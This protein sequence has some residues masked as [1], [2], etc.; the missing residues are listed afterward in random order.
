MGEDQD[1]RGREDS[2]GRRLHETISP[3]ER[4]LLVAAEAKNG[5][6]RDSWD[7]ASSLEELALLASTA[8]AQVVGRV[9]QRLE[10]PDPAYYVGRGKLQEIVSLRTTL[11]YDLVI[12]DDE[13]SPVQQRNLERA[14]QVKVL[15]RTA[16]ILDIFAQHARTREGRLQVELA[17]HE[18]LLPRL[19]GQWSHLERLGGGIGTRGPGETQLETDRRLIKRRIQHLRRELEEVRQHRALHRRRRA[20]EGLPLVSLV[21]YTNAGKSTLMR[22]LSGADVLVA[23]QLFA[24]LDPLTRRVRL[25]SGGFFL[26][27]D[28]VGFINKLPPQ[29]VA[30]FRATLEELDE[31]DLLLHVIDITHPRA[32]E[33]ADAVEKTLAELGLQA[34][35]RIAV[36]NKVDR[37]QRKDGRPIAGLEEV[38]D[39]LPHLRSWQPRAVLV[40]A[41]RGWGLDE[42]LQQ[43]EAA[44]AQERRAALDGNRG[45]AAMTPARGR[46]SR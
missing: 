38:T 23:D 24:T 22:A 10:R 35:A 28:T 3:P 12:F 11:G 31:A 19:R 26:L 18:Y 21:G 17:Q 40:S 36:L 34:K 8:G 15:D 45:T 4:A 33:Q 39:L 25:P 2:I 14:L 9:V 16:L 37:L 44:L 42:L 43:I 29:L 6:R 20:R 46:A 7:A 13:L 41:L 1:R 30:A 5:G 32:A 27:T